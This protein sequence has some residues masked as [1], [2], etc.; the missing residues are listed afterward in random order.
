MPTKF[1]LKENKMDK[2]I[3]GAYAS[4]R[5]EFKGCFT[6]QGPQLVNEKGG[7]PEWVANLMDARPDIEQIA[8]SG[9]KG[10][11]VWSRMEEKKLYMNGEMPGKTEDLKG[12]QFV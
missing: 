7:V 5:L 1:L 4:G 9:D 3:H 12:K 11:V 6:M 2:R 10:S 8:I